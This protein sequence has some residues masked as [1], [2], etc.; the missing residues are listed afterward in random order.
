VRV[1]VA[2]TDDEIR[3]CYPVMRQLRPSFTL[4]SFLER[5]GFQRRMGYHLVYLEVDDDAV[6]VAGYQIRETLV[7]GRFLHVDDL[8]TLDT[9]RSR[10]HGAV[11]LR[12]LV[13]H[14]RGAFL[15]E[16]CSWTPACG[17]ETRTGS[18]SARAWSASHTTTPSTWGP[19]APEGPWA[20]IILVK[21]KQIAVAGGLGPRRRCVAPL[22]GYPAVG[23]LCSAAGPSREA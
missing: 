21:R 7:D 13:G 11:L 9:R 22:P 14:S 1:R 4:E 3:V 19:P 16:P 10:G 23:A 6:A 18:T 17:V 15:R 2:E 8:V 20:A 5:V 12:W